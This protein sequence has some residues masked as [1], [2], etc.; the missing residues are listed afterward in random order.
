MDIRSAQIGIPAPEKNGQKDGEEGHGTQIGS[1]GKVR[2]QCW[3]PQLLLHVGQPGRLPAH[4]GD[5]A[6]PDGI[7]PRG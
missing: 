7:A 5:E 1:Y 3:C 6:V 4:N 2:V